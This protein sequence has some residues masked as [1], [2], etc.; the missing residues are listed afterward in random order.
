[1]NR[2]QWKIDTYAVGRQRCTESLPLSFGVFLEPYLN[3]SNY[4]LVPLSFIQ[5]IIKTEMIGGSLSQKFPSLSPIRNNEYQ[6]LFGDVL[7]G[8][9]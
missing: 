5:I 6:T 4:C 7:H 2:I 3:C 1:M 9:Y 8:V